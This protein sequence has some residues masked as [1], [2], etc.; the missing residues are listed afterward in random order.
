MNWNPNTHD[1]CRGCSHYEAVGEYVYQLQSSPAK[2]KCRHL[3]RC[4]R[5]ATFL[6]STDFGVQMSLGDL[7]K[8]MKG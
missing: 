5:V 4:G 7:T 1:Y 8:K 6:K 2:R 3:A